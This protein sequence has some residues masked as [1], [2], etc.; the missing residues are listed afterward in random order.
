MLKMQIV[1]SNILGKR[2]INRIFS[3]DYSGLV[4]IMFPK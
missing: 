4:R 2:S 1:G 3:V